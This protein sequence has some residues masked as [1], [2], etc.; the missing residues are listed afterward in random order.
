MTTFTETQTETVQETPFEASP[1][2]NW[3]LTSGD[4]A[5]S[6]SGNCGD[7]DGLPFSLAVADPWA[8]GKNI[9]VKRAS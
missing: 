8:F 7:D 2:R 4:D 6:C 5:K 3:D 9:W 1:A